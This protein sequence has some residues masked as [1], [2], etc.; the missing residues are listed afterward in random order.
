MNSLPDWIG[1][2]GSFEVIHF[3]ETDS[4]YNVR[5]GIMRIQFGLC[6]FKVNKKNEYKSILT[7]KPLAN[8]ISKSCSLLIGNK[9]KS[10]K[11]LHHHWFFFV[12]PCRQLCYKCHPIIKIGKKLFVAFC[13]FFPCSL[14]VVHR[15][16]QRK[17]GGRQWKCSRADKQHCFP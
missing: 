9:T 12:C 7:E 10:L 6:S 5:N 1:D 16:R 3:L 4:T 17:S 11:N 8:L 15:G 14:T 2:S 13:S